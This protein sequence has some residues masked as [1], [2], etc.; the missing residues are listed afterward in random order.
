MQRPRAIPTIDFTLMVPRQWR[1]RMR[2]GHEAFKEEL[3][4][5][6]W[7]EPKGPIKAFVINPE[8]CQED[9]EP[10]WAK[11]STEKE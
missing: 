5:K 8:L 11:L 9:L 1:I 10:Y 6:R 4:N 2:R 3:R 7:P